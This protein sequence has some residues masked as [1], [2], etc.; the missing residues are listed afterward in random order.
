MR[1]GIVEDWQLVNDMATRSM[2]SEEYKKKLRERHVLEGFCLVMAA[3]MF[4]MGAVYLLDIDRSLWVLQTIA[5]IGGI[6]NFVLAIRAILTRSWLPAAGLFLT[7]C[8][9]FGLLAWLNLT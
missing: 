2:P 7:S 3:V 8:A 5:V 9:C 6:L 4:A 1:C